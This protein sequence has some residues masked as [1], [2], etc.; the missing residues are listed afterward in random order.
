MR[1][2]ILENRDTYFA[3]P[4][5]RRDFRT[6]LRGVKPALLWSGYLLLLIFVGMVV[7]LG[8]YQRLSLTGEEQLR[9]MDSD[10]QAGP[11]D[12]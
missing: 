12:A 4:T 9:R 5:A 7:G 8:V 1:A 2:W 6:Q 10:D 3:N 11:P